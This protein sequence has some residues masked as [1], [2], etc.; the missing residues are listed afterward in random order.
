MNYSKYL[1]FIVTV[2]MIIPLLSTSYDINYNSGIMQMFQS[3]LFNV[4]SSIESFFSSEKFSAIDAAFASVSLIVN[5][6]L[7]II[8]LVAF[9]PLLTAN[10]IN[11]IAGF[12]PI[13][14]PLTSIFTIISYLAYVMIIWDIFF[15]NKTLTM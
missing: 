5:G 15:R 9:G 10:V 7:L 2:N 11:T 13:V 14:Q 4:Q 8:Q 1:L 12:T 6:A 3:T